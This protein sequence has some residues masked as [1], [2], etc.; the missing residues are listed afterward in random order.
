MSKSQIGPRASFP[1]FDLWKKVLARNASWFLNSSF[2]STK[3]TAA[4]T[5]R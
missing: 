1:P 3:S 4:S 2:R 5:S